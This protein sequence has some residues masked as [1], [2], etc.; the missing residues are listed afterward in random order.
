MVR[1]H[2]QVAPVRVFDRWLLRHAVF[3]GLVDRPAGYEFHH[4]D[5]R[6]PF[7]GVWL[8]P[9]DHWRVHHGLMKCPEPKDYSEQILDRSKKVL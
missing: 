1:G 6:R 3:E 8:T 9:K 5:Y 4:P 2:Y 7:Y